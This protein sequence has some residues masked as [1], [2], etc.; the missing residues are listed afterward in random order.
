MKSVI[1]A[2]VISATI[3]CFVIGTGG[4]AFAQDAAAPT[5]A[6]TAAVAAAPSVPATPVAVTAT[7]PTGAKTAK[8]QPSQDEKKKISQLC[9]AQANEKSLHG[10]DRQ[11]FRST[12]IRHGG[13]A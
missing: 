12:C 11:K 10:K 3:V 9:S 1:S 8:P 4:S 6:P 7:P 13:T 5:A 2:T